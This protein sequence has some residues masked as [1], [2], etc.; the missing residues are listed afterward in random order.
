MSQPALL[1]M[2]SSSRRPLKSSHRIRPTLISAVPAGGPYAPIFRDLYDPEGQSPLPFEPDE[3]RRILESKGW[4]DTN[5]DG[6]LD[7]DG[8][9]FSFTLV[10]NAGNQ[11]RADV[12]QI[13]QQQW[14]RIGVNARLQVLEFNT[15]TENLTSGNFEASLGGWSV[16]L[17]PDLTPLWGEDSPFNFTGYIN[18]DVTR[19]IEEAR[20][21]PTFE[22]AVV[23]WRDAASR[24]AQDQ[25]YTWL[26]YMDS[27][28]GVN[29]RLRGTKID[30]YGPYQNT[31]EWWIPASLRRPGDGPVEAN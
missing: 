1:E 21:Q 20:A 16:G 25:P 31:W 3:A 4:R 8:Q 29:N 5:A 26:Y 23:L 24:I 2:T 14:S 12:S 28:D 11:R 7:R 15:L 9:P 17:S 10:T 13:V 27:V 6:V 22:R 18:P 19:L 30:T